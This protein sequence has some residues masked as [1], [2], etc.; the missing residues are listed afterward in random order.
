MVK[1]IYLDH[2]A[3]TPCAPE[4]VEAMKPFWAD[5]F[6]NPASRHL[7]G[8]RAAKAIM[9]ARK[10]IAS[11]INCNKNEIFFTSGATESNNIVFLG[12]L[13]SNYTTKKRVVVS[14]I[15][16]KSITE[17]ANFL[18]ERGFDVV[19]LPATP[20]GIVD[21]KIARKAITADTTLV[22]VQAVNNEIGTIQ[23]IREIAILSHNAG[24]FFHTDAAQALGKIPINIYEWDCDLASFSAHKLNGPKGIGALYI[25]G[26]SKAWPWPVPFRGG[27]QEGGI[28]PGTSNV[29]GI[30]GFG[31]ACNLVE[32]K[33]AEKNKNLLNIRDFFESRLLSSFPDCII[34]GR[35]TSRVA[36]TTSVTIPGIPSDFIID[37]LATVCISNGSACSDGAITASSVL[38]SLGL[39][40]NTARETIRISFG[41]GT[42]NEQM[43]T[44]VKMMVSSTSAIK[45]SRGKR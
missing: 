25:K 16:H 6:G 3:T 42:T 22:S 44:L 41:V 35:N 45:S 43:E 36:G 32:E 20:D 4:V 11:S 23:P 15:E 18:I 8:R 5:N 19:F 40:Q 33:L 34:H 28:R 12:L 7:A 2:N 17:P 27:G 38:L 39:D 10:Q 37:N 1:L 14:A 24:A 29:P 30:V 9:I 21:I 26:G 13:L 31:K